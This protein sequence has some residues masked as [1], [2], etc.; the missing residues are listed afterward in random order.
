MVSW[1][2]KFNSEEEYDEAIIILS[3]TDWSKSI[4]EL[5]E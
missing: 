3:E 2:E 5:K 4:K 1:E